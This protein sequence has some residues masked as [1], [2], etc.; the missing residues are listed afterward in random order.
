MS[1]SVRVTGHTLPVSPSLSRSQFLSINQAQATDYIMHPHPCASVEQNK[2]NLPAGARQ[3]RR[4]QRCCVSYT[5]VG[6][7]GRQTYALLVYLHRNVHVNTLAVRQ[8]NQVGFSWQPHWHGVSPS[9]GSW[10]L[11][12]LSLTAS[13]TEMATLPQRMGVCFGC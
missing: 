8:R 6:R 1:S 3:P 13:S 11:P 7:E 12:Q 4:E 10:S 9:R 5:K 2:G